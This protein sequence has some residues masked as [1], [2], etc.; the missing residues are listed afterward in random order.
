[1]KTLGEIVAGQTLDDY[2]IDAL[3]AQGP[4][5]S[6]FRATDMKDGKQVAIKIPNLPLE[7]DPVQFDRFQREKEIGA[8]LN[9]PNLMHIYDD[10]HHSRPYIVMEWCNGRLLRQLIAGEGKLSPERSIKIT[11]GILQALEY[12]HSR[13][14]VHRD[15]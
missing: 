9:H 14:I 10:R 1:M 4:L 13:G 2:R 7:E 15:L 12:I 6:L 5:A 8:T 11:T 3:V